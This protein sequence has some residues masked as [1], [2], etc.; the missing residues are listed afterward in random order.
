MNTQIRTMAI[1]NIHRDRI[2]YDETILDH[3]RKTLKTT[4]AIRLP[5]TVES[6]RQIAAVRRR[7][8]PKTTLHVWSS[9][10]ADEYRVWLA[11]VPS[12]GS[13]AWLPRTAGKPVKGAGAA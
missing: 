6:M 13:R 3:V 8:P 7:L 5:F 9:L 12:N 2:V 4:Y 10:S 1:D 11:P